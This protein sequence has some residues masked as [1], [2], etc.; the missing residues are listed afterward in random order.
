L[1]AEGK[2]A[3]VPPVTSEGSDG[4]A[5]SGFTDA[6]LRE[7]A[8]LAFDVE[9]AFEGRSLPDDDAIVEKPGQ[10]WA[11]DVAAAFRGKHWRDVSPA[12]VSEYRYSL[13]FFTPAALCFYLPAFMILSLTWPGA[14]LDMALEGL[15]TA[16]T[17]PIDA[18][19]TEFDRRFVSLSPQ[20]RRIVAR[21]VEHYV[22]IEASNPQDGRE[23][24]IAYWCGSPAK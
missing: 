22:A 5:S 24:T 6:E 8:D 21:F 11:G 12:V 23:R 2:G 4:S 13:Q 15:F 17:P 9:T 7:G 19:D 18:G 14:T 20:Q 16:F 10:Y 1:C 3:Q